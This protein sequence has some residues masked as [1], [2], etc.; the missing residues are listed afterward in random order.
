MSHLPV[1]QNRLQILK[2]LKENQ[3][4]VVESPTGSGKTTQIPVILHEAGYDG[5][6][7]IGITQP[8][9]IATLSVCEFMKR[10]LEDEEG[11]FVGYK[12]RFNDTTTNLTH[13][14]VMT[15][16]ILL[17]EL[18]A[19]PLLSNYSVM[20]VDEAHERSLNI[21]FIIGMLKEVL[22]S[23]PDFKVIISS[24]TINTKKFS[25][26][27]DNCPVISIKAK[28]WP[29]E[30]IYKTVNI[31][32]LEERN[33]AICNIVKDRVADHSGDILIFLP[34]EFDIKNTVEALVQMD[35]KKD[36]IIYPLYGR[37]SKEEQESVFN[38]TPKGKT[39]VVVA[40]N[41]AETSITIDGIT[42]VIDSG[43][44]KMNFYNQKSFTSTLIALPISKS[45]CAQRK[46][47]AGRTQSGICYRLYSEKSYESR[48][49]Y[50]T[51]EILRTDLSEVI[52]RM[53]DLGLYDWEHFDFLTKPKNEAIISA[54][55]TLNF[56]GAIDSERHLTKVGELMVKFPLLPRHARVV[57]EAI[58]NYPSVIN[59]VII[60]ISFLSAKSPF[61]LPPGEENE[62]RAAQ[63]KFNNSKYGD[64]VSYLTIF[65]QYTK[66]DK[67]KDQ[68][69]YCTSNYMDHQSMQEIVH[70]NEQLSDIVSEIGIPL[71][72]GGS[73]HDY[74][75]C[76]ASGLKQNICVKEF[77]FMYNSL[78]AKEIFIHPGSAD[79]RNLPKYI[80]AGELVETSR[81]FARSVSPIAKD[82]LDDIEK[83]LATQ[84]EAIEQSS[85]RRGSSN[86]EDKKSR[87]KEERSARV[88]KA[89]E[90]KSNSKSGGS[91]TI[92]GKTYPLF[93]ITHKSKVA[94]IPYEDLMYL[95]KADNNA[96]RRAQNTPVRILFNGRYIQNGSKL[97]SILHM[98]GKLSIREA[99]IPTGV[100]GDR[101]FK[102]LVD[103]LRYISKITP[104]R[105]DSFYF[106]KLNFTKNNDYTFSAT[107]DYFKALDDSLY[108]LWQL[109]SEL[110]K[111][112]Q[113]EELKRVKAIYN[114]LLKIIDV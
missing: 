20:L 61:I 71:T 59:E 54:E 14:K 5:I 23:R 109:I 7:N 45:S 75:C 101:D 87:R 2:A 31:S 108:S 29:V 28:V 98:A 103:N 69:N 15:D 36:L 66:I 88:S 64:F 89:I 10:Q 73:I 33:Y 78:S 104:Y 105:N 92:Y 79:F 100:Y 41:I 60:A 49:A 42:T 1:Y 86:K 107:K 112:K 56:I 24:A 110:E 22:K 17:M 6:L 63:K 4:I 27:F 113:E 90:I 102:T 37:L 55:Q 74:I 18:K 94:T 53:S 47:R 85:G 99:L 62:A 19:D 50:S 12:M 106:I 82:W 97:Y 51:E 68:Q 76:I 44:A 13:I 52:L 84:L 77:G 58:I 11:S 114:S 96:Q 65:D 3:V 95:K 25:S 40:T 26:F 67:I 93:A 35:K 81:L 9:R 21:D 39:K 38:D 57:V 70:V 16:G 91:V 43:V 111:A 34:G 48:F 8:R 30:I 80:V 32:N 72:G 46:G 83:G